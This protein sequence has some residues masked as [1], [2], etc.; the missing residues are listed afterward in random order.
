MNEATIDA[1]VQAAMGGAG[2]DNSMFPDGHPARIEAPPTETAPGDAS[3][4]AGDP[5]DSWGQ[6]QQALTTNGLSP[7]DAYAFVQQG[8]EMQTPEGQAKQASTLRAQLD[9][10]YQ[11]RFKADFQSEL[12]TALSTPRGLQGLRRLMA[13]YETPEFA[14]Q[15]PQDPY[16]NPEAASP[17]RTAID[18]MSLEMRQMKQDLAEATKAAQE[19]RSGSQAQVERQRQGLEYDSF[20][21]ETPAAAG[22]SNEI[23]QELIAAIEARPEAFRAPGSVKRAAAQFLNR[24]QAVAS[25]LGQNKEPPAPFRSGGGGTR[26]S[27][28]PLPSGSSARAADILETMRALGGN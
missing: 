3:A 15:A 27:P 24:Y 23:A 7:E 4:P 20:I 26:Q 8:L 19:A 22:V 6:F 17:E 10:E 12:E 21:R 18:R 1:A 14:G 2:I 13:K 5:A 28:R 11:G 16:G 9:A 25:K